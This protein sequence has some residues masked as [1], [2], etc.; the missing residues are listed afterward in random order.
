MG[1]VA[2]GTAPVP[3]A[4]LFAVAY[5]YF[6]D[7]LHSRLKS[8]GWTDVR[9][10]YGFALLAARERPITITSLAALMSMTKQ[11]ASKL[12]AGM[13]AAGYLA[14]TGSDDGRVRPLHL[15]PRGERLLGAVE[16]IYRDLEAGWAEVIGAAAV[17]R[18]RADVTAA[19]TGTNDGRL[20]ALRPVW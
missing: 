18:V 4:R 15:S 6:I 5:R 3:L 12:A 9:P 16:G 13:V 20:P 17:E 10:A 1:G 14:E 2:D 8:A 7:E 19:V 11:A